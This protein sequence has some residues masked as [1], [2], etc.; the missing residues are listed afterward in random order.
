MSVPII[1]PVK[2]QSSPQYMSASQVHLPQTS[3]M[4]VSLH[5]LS[6]PVSLSSSP[7]TAEVSSC[8]SSRS[9]TC[10]PWSSPSPS[11]FPRLLPE[12]IPLPVSQN[13]MLLSSTGT[14]TLKKPKC[15]VCF[16]VTSCQYMIML[17]CVL[18]ISASCII[19]GGCTTVEV[20]Q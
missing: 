1:S 13:Q 3:A 5:H 7:P 10:T 8:T 6:S 20:Q 4:S 18:C 9:G 2:A 12:P 11:P 14:L 16:T 17:F 19:A 15:Q